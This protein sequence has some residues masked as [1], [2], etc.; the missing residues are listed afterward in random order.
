MMSFCLFRT[1]EFKSHWMQTG[2]P[3]F[4]Y[5]LMAENRIPAMNV[6]SGGI[7]EIR[8]TNF[9]IENI[10]LRPLMFQSGYLTIAEKK[11]G[12]STHCLH[13]GISES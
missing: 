1:R 13:A 12:W 2:N 11:E 4:L 7:D 10:E 3:M 6:E 5:R 8:L 9:D